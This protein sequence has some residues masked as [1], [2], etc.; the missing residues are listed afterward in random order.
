MFDD[1]NYMFE[2]REG[3]HLFPVT[4][5]QVSYPTRDGTRRPYSVLQGTSA[6]YKPSISN[7][8]YDDASALVTTKASLD[9]ML[10]AWVHNS[11]YSSPETFTIM[12][13]GPSKF[14]LLSKED[15]C[16]Y[17][18]R[19]S[20]GG[21][22]GLKP[23][24]CK[25]GSSSDCPASGSCAPGKYQQL[26]EGLAS[27][28]CAMCPTGTVSSGGST[29][30]ICPYGRAAPTV[31]SVSCSILGDSYSAVVPSCDSTETVADLGQL[32]TD[33]QA[34]TKV[35][36]PNGTVATPYNE[37]LAAQNG[38]LC[39]AASP[40]GRNTCK[41]K[42]EASTMNNTKTEGW[43]GAVLQLEWAD[44]SAAVCSTGVQQLATWL[45]KTPTWMGFN[46]TQKDESAGYYWPEINSLQWQP[47]GSLNG[48]N[49]R[50]YPRCSGFAHGGS[51]G[52]SMLT[53]G[54]GTAL[55]KC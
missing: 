9:G 53:F 18:Y 49:F 24:P 43:G 38:N 15:G 52:A 50:G 1:C 16:M 28:F 48:S 31:G 17:T 47:L 41:T 21:F 23:T 11:Q 20:Q 51:D 44:T 40:T 35:A 37:C 7:S 13:A 45:S 12:A 39:V 2:G 14:K 34:C 22:A 29:C 26:Q 36:C 8:Y 3:R 46:Y 10:A 25:P 30:S 5:A 19:I 33:E 55:G 54:E 4:F 27:H 42:S 6:Y 32:Y